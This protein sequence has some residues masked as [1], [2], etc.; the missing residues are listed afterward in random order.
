MVMTI[1]ADRRL[2]RAYWEFCSGF[3]AYDKAKRTW[4]ELDS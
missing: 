4:I 3:G 1:V 2:G